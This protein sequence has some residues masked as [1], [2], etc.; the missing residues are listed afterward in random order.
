MLKM[1]NGSV[2]NNRLMLRRRKFPLAT[3]LLVADSTLRSADWKHT[4]VKIS[5]T[6][7]IRPVLEFS[8]S[9]HWVF[10]FNRSLKA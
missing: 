6:D 9:F 8:I 5:P 3:F 1:V 7:M 2:L 10:G 4:F